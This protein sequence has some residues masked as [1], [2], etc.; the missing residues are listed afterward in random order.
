MSFF[1]TY[2]KME[3]KLFFFLLY[4]AIR[5]RLPQTLMVFLCSDLMHHRD[6]MPAMSLAALL[7]PPAFQEAFSTMLNL[8]ITFKTSLS[9]EN[10]NFYC[11]GYSTKSCRLKKKFSSST[12]SCPSVLGY[13]ED[14]MRRNLPLQPKT[15]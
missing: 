11:V 4:A 14:Q 3:Y 8:V 13:V 2:S 6:A 12:Y 10:T 1:N 9:D 5:M 15:V 7:I